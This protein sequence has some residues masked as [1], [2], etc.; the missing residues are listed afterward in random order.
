MVTNRNTARGTSPQLLTKK[1]ISLHPEEHPQHYITVSIHSH[2][3]QTQPNDIVASDCNHGDDNKISSDHIA[4]ATHVFIFAHT[5]CTVMEV[6]YDDCL[7]LDIAV[8]L[9]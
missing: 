2:V 9:P 4:I 5:L 8:T 3:L 1:H 7:I 6:H